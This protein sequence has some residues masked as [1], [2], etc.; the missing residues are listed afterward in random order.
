MKAVLGL[1]AV[2]RAWQAP[3]VKQKLAPFQRRVDPLSFPRVIDLG[4]G[5]GTNASVFSPAQYLGVD[6][7]ESYIDYA[8]THYPHRFEVWDLTKAGPE[9]EMFDLALINSVFHHLSDHE[10]SRVLTALSRHLRSDAVVHIIDLVLPPRPSLPRW[11][12]QLDR[13]DYARP[14]E[15]WR[16]LLG[17]HLELRH[18]EPFDVGLAGIRMWQMIYVEAATKS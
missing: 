1:P 3:F 4:C 17:K 18:F 9:I 15:H 6:L 2:Y 12:A 10:T 11:L 5:P 8:R 16:G 14:L 7:S 13:G